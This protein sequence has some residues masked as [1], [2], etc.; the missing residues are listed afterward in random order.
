LLRESD[1]DNDG[2]RCNRAARQTTESAEL[3]T[4]VADENFRNSERSESG[5]L[6]AV[7]PGAEISQMWRELRAEEKSIE[8][9]PRGGG[10]AEK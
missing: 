7:R 10:A 4:E 5:L 6:L 8:G 9:D 3:A 2:E 1:L